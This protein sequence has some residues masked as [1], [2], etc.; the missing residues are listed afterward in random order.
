MQLDHNSL[1]VFLHPKQYWHV[2]LRVEMALSWR[3]V[4]VVKL[5]PLPKCN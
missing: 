4:K 2:P 5:E 1:Y 3:H